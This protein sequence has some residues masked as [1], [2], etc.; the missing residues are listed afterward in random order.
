MLLRAGVPAAPLASQG[1][2]E[3]VVKGLFCPEHAWPGLVGPG[4]PSLDE[5]SAVSGKLGREPPV[6]IGQPPLLARCGIRLGF[7]KKK[8]QDGERKYRFIR[9][10]FLN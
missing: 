7:I 2:R 1:K 10:L 9:N 5:A 4:L 6:Y 3:A 8:S